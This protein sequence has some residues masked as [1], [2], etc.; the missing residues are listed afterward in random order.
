[1]KYGSQGTNVSACEL[2]GSV[3]VYIGQQAQAETLRVGRISKP[4]YCE[5]GLGRVEDFPH[6]LVQLIV[7]YGAPERWL[8]VR[9]RLQVWQRE[10]QRWYIKNKTIQK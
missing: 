10:R 2:H 8:T 6:P 5:R 3:A 1:M 9:H 7:G 4:V